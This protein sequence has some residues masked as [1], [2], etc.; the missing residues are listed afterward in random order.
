MVHLECFVITQE[1]AVTLLRVEG[2]M[3]QSSLQRRPWN[4]PSKQYIDLLIQQ[5]IFH[6]LHWDIAVVRGVH[7]AQNR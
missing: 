5:I 4:R 7:T 6:H 3:R 1:S 2:G